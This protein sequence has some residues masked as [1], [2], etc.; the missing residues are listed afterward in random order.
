MRSGPH[1]YLFEG[2]IFSW[3]T[4]I[5]DSEIQVADWFTIE[6]GKKFP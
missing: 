4:T 5:A 3:V 2:K 6:L 1:L